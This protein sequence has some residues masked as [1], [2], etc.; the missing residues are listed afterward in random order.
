MLRAK[1]VFRA[2]KSSA[3]WENSPPRFLREAAL[4]SLSAKLSAQSR[5]YVRKGF[6]RDRNAK[7]VSFE[8][9][10]K[11]SASSPAHLAE[12]VK[13]LNGDICK[14]VSNT[15]QKEDPKRLRV[16]GIAALC[17]GKNR[18]TRNRKRFT[19]RVM[20]KKVTSRGDYS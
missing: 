5:R 19:L 10:G 17:C 18:E 20:A 9:S 4:I 12:V 3:T 8:Q 16:R 1:F 14:L 2:E 6:L 15:P 13:I 11:E 7:Q